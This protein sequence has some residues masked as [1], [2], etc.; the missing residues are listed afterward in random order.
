MGQHACF[1][2]VENVSGGGGWCHH[3]LFSTN[4]N[5]NL[6]DNGK[7]HVKTCKNSKKTVK[8]RGKRQNCGSK[9]GKTETTQKTKTVK[10]KEKKN[11]QKASIF[12]KNRK[13]APAGHFTLPIEN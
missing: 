1:D 10:P 9:D 7:K 3:D 13:T 8:D 4:V 11:C 12:Y 2:F 6:L 5:G